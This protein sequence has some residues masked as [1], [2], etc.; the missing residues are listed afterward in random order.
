MD[1]LRAGL[2]AV[3]AERGTLT[4]ALVVEA[5]RPSSS[6]LHSYVFDRSPRAA[7]EAYYLSRARELIQRFEV[8]YREATDDEPAGAV[9][10]WQSVRLEQ[11]YVYEPVERV[12]SDP[13]LR[14]LKLADMRREYQALEARYAAFS[15]FVDLARATVRRDRRRKRNAG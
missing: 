10:E 6:P 12:V 14:R 3:Y 11:G 1:P 4:P 5:A 15:E 2:R 13:F 8:T 7:A 9:R